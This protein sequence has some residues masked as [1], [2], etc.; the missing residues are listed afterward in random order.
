MTI[1]APPRNRHAADELADVRL[2]IRDL[3]IR[4]AEL[5][6]ELLADGADRIGDQYEA[7]VATSM[8]HRLDIKAVI[9]YYGED[10][11]T[12]FYGPCTRITYVKLKRR[13]T[14]RMRRS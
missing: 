14:R 2:E 6:T 13:V 8:Q 3:K 10:A 11:M 12:R 1:E 9:A 5:R 7:V 4:E